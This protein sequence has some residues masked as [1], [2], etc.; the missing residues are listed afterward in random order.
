MLMAAA[1]LLS[2][3]CRKPDA[4]H[5]L[6]T[7]AV[8]IGIDSADW[9]II[10]ALAAQGRMPNLSRLRSLGV[11]GPIETLSDVPLSP[12]IW[13]SIAT[14][15]TPA[16][17]GITWFMV[18]QADGSRV[19]VRSTN[20]KTKAIWNML[21]AGDRRPVVVGWWATYPAEDVGDGIIVSDALGFHGFGST[22]REGDNQEKTH[23]ASLF[24]TVDPLVPPRQQLP[25]DFVKRFV[26]LTPEEYRNEM[27]DPGRY[28]RADPTNPIHLFQEYAVTAQGYTAIAEKLLQQERYDLFMVYFEQVDSFSHLFMKYA[29]P[30]LPWVDPAQ[31]ERYKDV[32]N[33]WYVYQDE[34][35]GRVLSHVDLEKTAV[36]VMSDHG[37]KS[38]DRR[39]RSEETVDV[40][41]AHLDHETHGIFIAA[42]PHI[43]KNATIENASVLDVTPTLLHYLGF[44][45]AKDMDGKVL[46]DVFAPD[47]VAANPIRYVETYEPPAKA[48]PSPSPSAS[49]KVSASETEEREKA[50][51]ALGYIGGGASSAKKPAAGATPGASP[52]ASQPAGAAT[53][54]GSPQESSPEIHNNLGRIYLR[55]GRTQ[56]AQKEFE[57]ALELD[58]RNSEAL[59][60]LA[61]LA[62]AEGR[63]AQAEQLIQRALQVDP[64]SSPAL[65]QLAE[66]RRD[67]GNLPEALR[68]FQQ[69]LQIDNSQPSLYI[70]YGDVLQRSGKYKEAEEAFHRVLQLEPDSFKARYNLGVTYAAQGKLDQAE[71]AYKDALKVNPDDPEAGKALN[72]LGY[73]AL[74]RGKIDDA[75]ANFQKAVKA[76]PG[77]LESRYNLAM[78]YLR[79][80][81]V[82]DAIP[83]L[84][85]AAKIA[86]NHELVNEQLGVAYLE[87]NRAEDAYR[88][89]LL[90]QRLY[91]KNWM[92]PL[93]LAVVQSA[94]G[95]PEPARQLLAEALRLGGK[96]ARQRAAAYPALQKL[97]AEGG[98][99]Q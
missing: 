32:V 94:A 67:Q 91:P 3:A 46:T 35:L 8:V 38:G 85:E 13:T 48:A 28:P 15:K 26:H 27:F 31:A 78:Q 74:Q 73:I 69:A 40:K 61:N 64:S 21:A 37:F 47:F 10:D 33:E 65:A 66:L 83:L 51:R 5:D 20:R 98:K 89:F 30:L 87:A 96:E 1:T 50:L 70:G 54:G 16:K 76:S 72:N 49:E 75:I 18:D 92:A 41:R 80:G 9:K 90:V 12:V 86:P 68:L 99:T 71:A 77:N 45:V 2:S 57:A 55:D 19:P 17:H 29:P 36:F 82:K 11:S 81:Q 59:L 43:R 84:E 97:L 34:L 56:D 24:A 52:G 39:I 23:P 25:Y 93:G 14:G 22:A 88:S 95:H 79:K 60:N 62:G 7:R 44:P 42:G 63:S 58:P 4:P 6:G 53:P